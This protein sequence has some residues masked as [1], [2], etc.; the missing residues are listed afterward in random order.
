MVDDLRS[1]FNVC[2]KEFKFI[3]FL[4]IS[5][6]LSRTKKAKIEQSLFSLLSY[7]AVVEVLIINSRAL[8]NSLSNSG[9]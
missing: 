3:V 4:N 1:F 2:P 8:K 7:S 9:K 5:L 6:Q